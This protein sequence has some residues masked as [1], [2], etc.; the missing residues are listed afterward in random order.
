M[1]FFIGTLALL[2]IGAVF[3]SPVA[4]LFGLVHITSDWQMTD[5]RSPE[6]APPPPWNPTLR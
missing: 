1:R 2:V 6:P 3:A 5:S 4:L